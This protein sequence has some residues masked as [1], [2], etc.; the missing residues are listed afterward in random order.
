M[1]QQVPERDPRSPLVFVQIAM[2]YWHQRRYDDAIAWAKRSLELGPRHL[3]AGEFLA[4][5]CWKKGDLDGF[6]AEN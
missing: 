6:L 5:A 1:K 2:C 4:G 3:L